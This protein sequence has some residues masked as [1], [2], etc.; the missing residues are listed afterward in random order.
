MA[1]DLSQKEPVRRT[2]WLTAD[3]RNDLLE[4]LAHAIDAEDIPAEVTRVD[5]QDAFAQVSRAQKRERIT[6]RLV[7][8]YNTG[9]KMP[10]DAIPVHL[11]DQEA[12]AAYLLPLDDHTRR[13]LSPHIPARGWRLPPLDPEKA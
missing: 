11:S 13:L 2:V 4:L 3:Q 1:P 7:N 10:G 9:L 5:I 6:L 12:L 8:G